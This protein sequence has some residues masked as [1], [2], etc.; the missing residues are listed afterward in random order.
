MNFSYFVTN[1]LAGLL[2]EQ[3]VMALSNAIAR[4]DLSEASIALDVL[5]RE[6]KTVTEWVQRGRYTKSRIA[7]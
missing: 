1:K 6:D 2:D 7:A 5:F 4:G 3:G